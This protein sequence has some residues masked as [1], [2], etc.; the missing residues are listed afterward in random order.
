MIVMRVVTLFL[1]CTFTRGFSPI[2][3]P[4]NHRRVVDSPTTLSAT[5]QQ[6]ISRRVALVTAAALAAG[7]TP[8][9]AA[10]LE[11]QVA[12]LEK[13]NMTTVNTKGAPEKHLPQVSVVVDGDKKTVTVVVPHVMDAE[14]PHFIEYV[15]LKDVK[16]NK[17]LAAKAFQATDPSPPT[18]EATVKSGSTSVQAMLFCNLH[19][20]WEGDSVA[21]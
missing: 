14:K 18:L 16:S 1:V 11:R 9:H 6:E 13:D 2:R 3:A 4:Q 10:S 8:A 12:K 5:S 21:V 17:I 19:G 20:L 15:W 7:A